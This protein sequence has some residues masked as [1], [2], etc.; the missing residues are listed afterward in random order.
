MDKHTISNF[1][2]NKG[3]TLLELIIVLAIGAII[4]SAAVGIFISMIQHQKSILQEQ[5]FLNQVSYA[6]EYMSRTMRIAM[7]DAIGNC[8]SSGVGVGGG[9]GGA[10]YIYL[11]T[12]RDPVSGFY[13]GIKFIRG[14]NSVCE[15]FYLD[16]SGALKESKDGITEPSLL[17]SYVKIKYIRFVI[18]GDKA[19]YG[20]SENDSIQPRVTI[21][22]DVTVQT[23]LGQQEKIIQTTISWATLNLK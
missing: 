19:L 6:I 17:A 15:E 2:S 7:K 16:G 5:E 10:G 4:I 21:G 12:R 14:D 9:S 1:K 11:L 20:A 22:L 3:V 23:P 13:T 18:N 8:T